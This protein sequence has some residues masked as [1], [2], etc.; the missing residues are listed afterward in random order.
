MKL[1]N[2]ITIINKMR[3]RIRQMDEEISKVKVGSVKRVDINLK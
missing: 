2:K 1:M 3:A